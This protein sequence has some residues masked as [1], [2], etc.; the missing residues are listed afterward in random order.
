MVPTLH[1]L[2]RRRPDNVA[3]ILDALQEQ[4]L[5]VDADLRVTGLNAA[6]ARF[7]GVTSVGATGRSLCDLFAPDACPV[8]CV[9]ETLETGRAIVDYQTV[10]ELPGGRRFDV[11]V[12]TVPLADTASDRRGA[13]LILRDVTEVTSLRK[14]VVGRAGFLGL[15]GKNRRM[16]ELYRLI[17][18]V[19]PTDATVLIRGETGTGKE[20]V[21]RAIH[22]LSRR[23]D[24]PFVTVNCSA[25]AETLLESEL[26]GHV[27][28]AFTGAVSDRR[29]RFEEARGGT[30]FL[31]E[32]GDVN[33]VVQV[34]LLRVLQERVV[35]RVGDATP[36]P[37]DVRIVT[38]T[39]RDLEELLALGR[40]R[41]DFYYRIKVVTLEL[42]PL[43]ERR[44]DI[45]LLLEHFLRR[46]G[47]DAG[48]VTPEAMRLLL[49]HAWPGNIRELENVVEHA[50][51]LSR[52]DPIAPRH[53]PPELRADGRP[54][55]GGSARTVPRHSLAEKRLIEAALARWRGHRGRTAAEL[56]IDRTTLWRKMREYGL[57]PPSSRRR[58]GG[59]DDRQR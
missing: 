23:A 16:Q 9:R 44:D 22:R 15:V 32:I 26:F 42:P 37:V 46:H 7:L 30:L 54:G 6:A 38:A 43:R 29:G 58:R 57:L 47:R 45:P 51:V 31:D 12:R 40:I 55:G 1:G 8:A 4:V 41:S 19:A 59:S 49:D 2:C 39:N 3:R 27:R 50:V 35:E 25:L 20:L 56:G 21:A 18:D 13:A 5:L 53:L 48:A 10:V 28:G 17:E 34:K 24:G 52:G 33:P 11:L 14:E 36:R